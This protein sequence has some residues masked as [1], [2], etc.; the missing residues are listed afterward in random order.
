[1]HKFQTPATPVDPTTQVTPDGTANEP[2]QPVSSPSVC[3]LPLPTVA[4]TPRPSQPHCLPCHYQ[5]ELP[6]PMAPAVPTC[7]VVDP[8]SLPHQ[9]ILHV[10]D[11]FHT[12]FNKFGITHDYRH[13]P[14]YDPDTLLSVLDLSD[15][16]RHHEADLNGAPESC[17][18]RYRPSGERALPWPWANMS[19]WQLM[20]W[21]LTGN[22]QKSNGEVTCLVRDVI[23][24][25][26]F[27]V[28]DFTNFDVSTLLKRLEDEVTPDTTTVFDRD[29]WREEAP[30]IIIPTCKKQQEGNG[31]SFCVPGLMYQS[32]TAMI[33]T[34]FS[35][36]IARWF[37]LT[38]FKHI[39]KSPSGR[40]QHIYDELYSSDAWNKAHDE[41]Q[42]QKRT[43]DC[44]LER[45][46]VGLMFWS[47][48]T[49]LSQFGHLSTWPIYLFFGNL[50][51][52]I[53]AS[54]ASGACYPIAF[55]PPVSPW[56]HPFKHV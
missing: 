6:E 13:R 55:I 33:K 4:D 43:D 7:P 45:V 54:P 27:D 51:K 49:Q 56:F 21:K 25:V 14:S 8:P 23:Q 12:A 44:Q 39:W 30:E 2:T 37:H 15:L 46:V 5:D 41:I 24:A 9:V 42:K 32:L 35:E 16:P 38:P 3:P 18:N 48:S 22:S 36:P 40:E 28:D 52:Y 47:D 10:F 26:D 1:M 11:S 53:H 20:T 31:P 34:A 29:G 50:S 17:D 19:I